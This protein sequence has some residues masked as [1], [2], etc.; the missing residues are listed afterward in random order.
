MTPVAQQQISSV[1]I[2][3][4]RQGAELRATLTALF[5]SASAPPTAPSRGHAAPLLLRV[6]AAVGGR[7]GRLRAP[8]T[9]PAT[10][11]ERPRPAP[12]YGCSSGRGP[13]PARLP[14]GHA[15][16][17]DAGSVPAAEE[18]GRGERDLLRPRGRG[19]RE[20]RIPP[21]PTPHFFG[22][23]TG[24][25]LG[26]LER[27]GG[28]KSHECAGG[29]DLLLPAQG[30]AAGHELGEAHKVLDLMR[31]GEFSLPAWPFFQPVWTS[32]AKILLWWYQP[33]LS[34]CIPQRQR[35]GLG[36]HHG[37]H[38]QQHAHR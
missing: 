5:P 26:S 20:V 28:L 8:W 32:R 38:P 21:T 29:R 37:T 24:A 14:R 9:P 36:A 11:P 12:R 25:L 27:R 6:Y 31:E 17:R 30:E 34:H 2:Y 1:E 22:D 3:T 7:R 23:R 4:G 19:A 18:S 33:V 15:F 16:A 10:P 35:P 13:Q